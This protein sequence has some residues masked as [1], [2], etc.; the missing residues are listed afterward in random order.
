MILST[1]QKSCWLLLSLESKNGE[2]VLLMRLD[3]PDPLTPVTHVNIPSGMSM[4][5]PFRLLSDA[6]LIF[7]YS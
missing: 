3:L 7:R 5:T 6:P 2:R 4:S 1:F